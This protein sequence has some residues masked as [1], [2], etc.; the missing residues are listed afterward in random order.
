MA[1]T[2]KLAGDLI[3]DQVEDQ[4]PSP[5]DNSMVSFGKNWTVITTIHM[6]KSNIEY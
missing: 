3:G 6:G 2:K 1:S 5:G 4:G